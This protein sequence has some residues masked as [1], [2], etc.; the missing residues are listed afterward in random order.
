MSITNTPIGA[1]HRFLVKMDGK[2]FAGFKTLADANKYIAMQESKVKGNSRDKAY[3]AE[4]E[5]SVQDRGGS[6]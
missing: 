3:A 4:R 6:E 1:N 2:P 5:W